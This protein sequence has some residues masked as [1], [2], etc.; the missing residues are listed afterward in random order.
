M[1]RGAILVF[2][3]VFG[4]LSLGSIPGGSS[5]PQGRF[6]FPLKGS[7]LFLLYGPQVDPFFYSL[8]F[9]CL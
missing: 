6:F 4:L 2:V 3:K 5:N 8:F 1:V 9:I 7:F